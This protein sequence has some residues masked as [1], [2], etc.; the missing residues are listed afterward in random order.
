MMPPK[1]VRCVFPHLDVAVCG[2]CGW[3]L[4]PRAMAHDPACTKRPTIYGCSD[5]G[6]PGGPEPFTCGTCEG[7]KEPTVP[8]RACGKPTPM[9]GTQL[10]HLCWQANRYAGKTQPCNVCKVLIPVSVDGW[11]HACKEKHAARHC[12]EC[13]TEAPR[14]KLDCSVGRV[15]PFSVC[16]ACNGTKVVSTVET[17]DD[18]HPVERACPE[19]SG[20]AQRT[21]YPKCSRCPMQSIISTKDGYLCGNCYDAREE[22]ITCRFCRK[23]CIRKPSGCCDRCWRLDMEVRSDPDLVR[24]M[25]G[26]PPDVKPAPYP[27]GYIVMAFWGGLIMGSV[28]MCGALAAYAVWSTP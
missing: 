10:C 18:G 15:P 27:T 2:E 22:R 12:K 6:I 5:C 1:C 21:L 8:C 11:C 20:R 23:G 13:K 26:A 4:N 7:K 19:C 25:L 17:D 9:L 24:R 16:V 28:I 3:V 14:H